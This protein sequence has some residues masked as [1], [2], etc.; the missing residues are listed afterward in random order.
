M[1]NYIELD[2]RFRDLTDKER[3]D[4][5]LLALWSDSEPLAGLPWSELIKSER[6]VILA[7]AGTGKTREMVAQKKR[8]NAEG[9]S[10]FFIPVEAL[11]REDVRG[12]L[13]TEAGEVERF[14]QWLAQGD[15]PGWFF[16]DS[17]DEL[18]LINGKLEQALGKLAH[19]LGPAR[20]RAH[21]LISCRPTDWRPVQDMEIFQTKFPTSDPREQRGEWSSDDEFLAPFREEEK[22]KA[23]TVK[24]GVPKFRCVVL[25]AL[26]KRQIEIY[27]T[28]HGVSDPKALLSEIQ[29]HEVWS[30][31]RRPLDL[32]GLVA[33]WKASGGLGTLR[34]Q[35]EVDIANSLR[36]DPNR[37]GGGIL[38]LERAREGV[39]RLALAM[40]LTKTRT[41]RAPEQDGEITDDT[42]S[43]DAPT[44]LADWPGDE[45][46]ALL[47]R[48][49]FD[50]ATY[51][52]IRFHH[53]SI[54][55]F[56]TAERLRRLRERGMTKRK[57]LSMIFAQT[58]GERVVIPSMRPIAAWL[59][60]D[61]ADVCREVLSREPEV[62]VLY[63]DPETL[64]HPTRS[65]LLRSF[66]SAYN[67][68][69]W[70][71]L[72]MPVAEMQRLAKG[73]LAPDIKAAWAK[74]DSNEEI[75]EFLLKLVW[76]G[77]I[78]DCAGIASEALLDTARADH[79]R[80][81]AARALAEC[82]RN[83]LLR[84]AADD[85]LTNPA[86]WPDRV[87]YSVADDL[88]PKVIAA[89]ELEKLVRRTPEPARS[90]SGFSWTLYTL[91]DQLE[92]GSEAAKSL[93][94][95]LCK[96]VREGD[97]T[98]D[99]YRPR[100]R[101]GYLAPALG[102]LCVRQMEQGGTIPEDLVRAA[103]VAH[104]FHGED[105]VGREEIKQ[106]PDLIAASGGAR[107]AAFWTEFE[108]VSRLR[109][110]RDRMLLFQALREGVVHTLYNEDR[111]WLL[112]AL[113][114]NGDRGVREIALHGLIELWYQRGRPARDLRTLRAAVAHDK[115]LMAVLV[116][117]TT[118][119]PPNPDVAKWQRD[120]QD[121]RS[122]RAAQRRAIE[123]SW[124][125]WKHKLEANPDEYM[126]GDKRAASVWTML[127]WLRQSGEDNSQL[128]HL[129]W[130][131]IR[132]VLGDGIG[133]RFEKALREYWRA[134]EPPVWSKRKV[135]ERNSIWNSQFIA[136][137]GLSVE[138]STGPEWAAKLSSKEALRAAKWA[139]TE[140]NG[141]PAWLDALAAA[142]PSPTREALE[143]ELAAELRGVRELMHPHTL[144][145]LRYGEGKA[146][147]LSAPYLRRTLLDWPKVPRDEQRE[148]NYSQNLDTVLSIL[149][150]AKKCDKD[151][152][153]LCEARF[154]A[155]PSRFSSRVWLQGLCACDMRRGVVALRKALTKVPK[156]K[157]QAVAIDWFGSLFGDRDRF[158][159]P[160]AMD[161]DA[162]LL[163]E[164]TKLI[165]EYVRPAEDIE[166][167]GVYS[168]GPRDEAE[169]ARH[170]LLNALIGKPGREAY[171]ALCAL[172]DEPLFAHFPDRLRVLARERAASDS[173][174]KPLPPA[175]FR[176]RYEAP[177]KNRDELFQIMLDRLD[178][179]DHDIRHH[180]LSDRHVLAKI[181]KEPE[182][183][184]LLAKKLQDAARGHYLVV[185]EDEV[186]DRKETDIRLLA[187]GDV[188]AVIEVKIGDNWSVTQLESMLKE[189]LVGQYLR[190]ANCAAGCYLVTYA[191]RTSF[192]EPKTRRPLTFEAVIARLSAQAEAIE[193][194]EN[195]RIRLAVFGLDF[196]APLK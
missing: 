21:I 88:F 155:T 13:A 32:G 138:Q 188:R 130:R 134:T 183:Q 73:D 4:P 40:T 12:Y 67:G 181:E 52:R 162:D 60:Y 151:V 109:G 187:P 1:E 80:V 190:H 146:R 83:D 114:K 191:G 186:V 194:R 33:T 61:D 72:K 92:P 108:F 79:T 160:V 86:R 132:E 133:E 15:P 159:V 47:R 19:A 2:R 166:H 143:A 126:S 62:L 192:H 165:Y 78:Q 95:L 8:L 193:A 185:R 106:L 131:R 7:E 48:A 71:G 177:P 141:A 53:R 99:L 27:A 182:L 119:R 20:N 125:E 43:L 87:V 110:E 34:Q 24:D 101:F 139:L 96:L 68:G 148:K 189:Q 38:S 102:K 10:A 64:P 149:V 17:V 113:K 157:R 85:M 173:E 89:S 82:G 94:D 180:D 65:A 97:T 29:R 70:R 167:E 42:S 174:P 136:L 9:Y 44:I 163:L 50:P 122:R 46:K 123:V 37:Q 57:L 91:V 30:F 3:E 171:R 195:G 18:K 103:T 56:L 118:P 154:L 55:E 112:R 176:G 22:T 6:V 69:G 23:K 75:P 196:R 175:E 58:Y 156:N 158:R 150:L 144:N 25:Q 169:S 11:D 49:I 36:D 161:A 81:Y 59:S 147:L 172:A 104:R 16:L 116:E 117:Q 93:R 98:A 77:A 51:G 100:S 111:P 66:V 145:L 178:D 170:R 31:A 164:L 105:A 107:E 28:A 184:P 90:V 142:H 41:I 153:D 124:T 5:T 45:V 26:G 39:E 140:L 128:A 168:P 63:G 127:Q 137:T 84:Q 115:G 129:N 76:L 14:D 179:I 54:Q 120:D 152:A 121:Y 35:H 74:R 135:K